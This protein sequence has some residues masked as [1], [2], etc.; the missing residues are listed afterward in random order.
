MIQVHNLSKTYPNGTQA[1]HDFTLNLTTGVVGLVGPNG[2][3]KTTLMRMLATLLEP[4]RGEV[5]IANY[6]PRSAHD[7]AEIRKLIGYLPQGNGFHLELT[8]EENL[9]YFALLKHINSRQER[10]RQIDYVLEAT[11][12][13]KVRRSRAQ[14]LSGGMRR[15]LGI[16]ITLLGHPRLLILDEPT[17]GLDPEE[18]YRFR[19]LLSEYASSQLVLLSSHIVEDIEQV[20]DDF[21]VIHHGKLLYHGALA[22]LKE[23]MGLDSLE[24][25]YLRLIHDTGPVQADR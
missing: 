9:D 6:T 21:V 11:G 5:Q 23:T 17:A 24:A 2:A 10:S 25:A 13:Q 3:G 12:L 22:A 18:R 16:A 19:A 4:T 20:A 7:R 8:A 1:L 14:T 15:R